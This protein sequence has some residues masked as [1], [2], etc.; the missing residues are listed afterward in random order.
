VTESSV[1][2]VTYGLSCV[3]PGNGIAK[4]SVTVVWTGPTPVIEFNVPQTV[5]TTLPAVLSWSSNVKP[6]SISGGGLSLDNLAASG[7]TTTTQATAGD[8]TYTLTCGSANAQAMI[9]ETVSYVT[10]SLILEETGSDRILG[11]DFELHWLT[12][13]NTCIPSGGAPGDGWGNTAFFNSNNAPTATFAP[14]VTTLGTY[15]YTLTCST[16]TTSVQQ[17]VTATFE[18]NAPYT[19]ATLA[20][21]T[22]TYSNSPADYVILN[23]N[24]NIS[25]CIINGIQDYSLNDP[26]NI[27]Y[28][29]QGSATLAPPAPGTYSISVTCAIPGNTPTRVTSTPV[30]LTV[31]PPPPPTETISI[32]PASVVQGQAFTISWSSTNA[33]NCEGTGGIPNSGWDTNGAYALPPTGQFSYRAGQAGNFTFGISCQS[34]APATVAPTSTNAIL[35]VQDLTAT[36]QSSATSLTVGDAFTLSWSSSGATGCTAGGGGAD[37]SPWSGSLATSGQLVQTATESGTFTYSLTCAA[38]GFSATQQV[39][40]NVVASSSSTG[41][42]AGGH[43]GGGA[44]GLLELAALAAARAAGRRATT[45]RRFGAA[46]R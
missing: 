38:N 25:T 26:L 43:G 3:F 18:Q 8:V 19:T 17:S 37:G 40:I 30:T 15:T 23:W 28:Q 22:V 7:T 10:P 33:S 39:T 36:L 16:G 42:S 45:S 41:S 9:N 35:T 4:A 6:C 20:P 5:W 44:L 2:T 11:Q 14:N 31:L 32:S 46:R 21:T 13:A 34:I 24:S 27:P 29:A 12:A 1:T